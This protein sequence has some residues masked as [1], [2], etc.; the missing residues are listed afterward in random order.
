LKR[1]GPEPTYSLICLNGSVAAIR[2]GMMNSVGVLLLPSANS[3][4]PYG[5]LS[6][7]RNVLSSTASNASVRFLIGPP[8]GASRTIQR[9][10][11]ATTSLAS[12]GSPS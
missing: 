9:L 7:N 8:I 6:R 11:L 3:I 10:I 12:T 5:W 4:F 2:S 1:I